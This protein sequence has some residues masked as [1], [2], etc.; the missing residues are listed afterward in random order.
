MCES[1][2]ESLVAKDVEKRNEDGEVE[3]DKERRRVNGDNE[4]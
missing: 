3:M 2:N 4:H 1:D